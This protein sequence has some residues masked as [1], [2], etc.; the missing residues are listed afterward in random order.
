M[1]TLIPLL[2]VPLVSRL[3]PEASGGEAFYRRLSEPAR[4]DA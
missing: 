3:R 1:T 2:L 4:A